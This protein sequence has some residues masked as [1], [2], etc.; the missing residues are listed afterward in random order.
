MDIVYL[1]WYVSER[2]NE[3]DTEL[4]IG[5]YLSEA[6][7]RDAI[8]R[9]NVQPG[10]VDYP[11]GFEIHPYKIGQDHWTEGFVRIAEDQVP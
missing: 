11:E 9:L 3:E 10:F 6:N 4:L 8:S 5:V 7:A 1:L 2:E